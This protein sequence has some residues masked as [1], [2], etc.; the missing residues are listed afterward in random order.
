MKMI[1]G[2]G[3]PGSKYKETKHNIGFITLD[4]FA[5]QHNMAFNKT[6]FEAVYA[7]GFIG[8]E[9]ILLVKPQTFMNDSGRAVRP[10]M[11]YFNVELEDL[12][13][14]YD[15]LD[16]PVGRLR[17]RQK[18]SAGGHNGI[19]SIIQHIDTA[20]FNRIRIGIDRPMGKQTV[21]QHVLSGFPKNQHE[22]LLIAVKDS[23]AAL[24]Y[25]IEGHPFLDV[26][27]QFNKKKNA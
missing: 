7:E 16:L 9:K 8:T 21:V 15:D 18:G 27:N 13:V 23:V 5:V 20:D 25:W 2:L 17:L 22:E 1:V 26:M 11:D 3:N 12:V 14:V 10:L 19:K 4:E 24:D 6:K